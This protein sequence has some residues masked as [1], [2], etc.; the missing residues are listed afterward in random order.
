MNRNKLLTVFGGGFALASVLSSSAQSVTLPESPVADT[1]RPLARS[2]KAVELSPF[3][4][5]GEADNSYGALN[6]ASITGFRT[7]LKS[8]PVSADIFNETFIRDIGATSVEDMVKAFAPGAGFAFSDPSSTNNQPGDRAPDSYVSL[9]GLAAPAQRM[10]GFLPLTGYNTA[11]T[12]STGYSDNFNFERVEVI[13]G[14]QALLYGFG[15]GG[16]VVNM[17][18]KPARFDRRP[19]G[20]LRFELNQWGGKKAVLDYGFGG[21]RA[22]I[23][24][25]LVDQNIATAR[26]GIGGPMYGAHVQFA[27]KLYDHTVIRLSGMHSY[28]NRPYAQPFTYT[29]AS[30]ASDSRSGQSLKYLLASNQLAASTSGPGGGGDIGSKIIN[31]GNVDSWGGALVGE[32]TVDNIAT[33]VVETKVNRWLSTQ[34]SLGV[35]DWHEDSAGETASIFPA[36]NPN[37]PLG[38]TALSFSLENDNYNPARTKA[39]RF[40]VL[41]QNDFFGGRAHSNTILGTDFSRVKSA[42]TSYRYYQADQNWNTLRDAA[43]NRIAQ[44]RMVWPLDTTP[45]TY[46]PAQHTNRVTFF[47]VNYNREIANP[48]DPRLISP[49]NPLGVTPGGAGHWLIKDINKG[50]FGANTTEWLGGRLQT[51]TGFRLADFYK[52]TQNQGAAPTLQNPDIRATHLRRGTSLDLNIGANYALLSWLRPYFALSSSYSPP[53]TQQAGPYGDDLDSAKSRGAEVG[54]KFFDSQDRISGSLTGYYVLA[55]N[56]GTIIQTALTTAINPPGING[57]IGSPSTWINVDRQT[58]GVQLALSANPSKNWRL[59]FTGAWT[60]GTLSSSKSY[61]L[62]YN[63]QF[64]ANSQGQLT[65]RDGTVVYVRPTFSAASPVSTADTAGALPLTIAMMNTPGGVYYANPVAIS[66]AILTTSNVG[67]VLAVND[68]VHGPIATGIAG[69][70]ISRMQ[71]N[72]GFTPPPSIEVA[73]SGDQTTGYPTYSLATTSVY[74]V[75]SGLLKG[76]RFG[77]TA[78]A[79]WDLRAFYYFVSAVAPGAPRALFRYPTMSQFDGILGYSRKVG[80]YVV[81]TQVNV[82][83]VS[84]HYHVL[85]TPNPATGFSGVRGAI[86]TQQP[87]SYLWTNSVSF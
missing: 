84:N 33:L 25:A 47:G 34:L 18:S 54:L 38:V 3:E 61:D 62:L 42:F 17:V 23:R 81:S 2:E 13:N 76:L 27:A 44:G 21:S 78:R 28:T 86:F 73:R 60:A 69:L 49:I 19:F 11:S 55:K 6:S 72:P 9:R 7:E 39:I 20:G 26:V 53:M 31:W 57:R 71:I 4:V 29:A 12:T 36:N 83:N 63:D 1:S 43:G 85:I 35:K 24:L 40:A 65:Y 82:N 59:R 51:L 41:A 64:Y 8:L 79:G 50:V 67:R 87:R 30:A 68:P 22:A 37:N 58:R 32:R 77:G 74:T 46:L 52:L 48:V 5:Q 56:E 75:P 14:P 16:G 15:G 10:D 66:G 45:Q 80:R 70:P